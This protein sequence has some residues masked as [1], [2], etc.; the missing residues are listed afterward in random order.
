MTVT[1]DDEESDDGKIRASD[2]L[3]VETLSK[4]PSATQSKSTPYKTVA[5][6]D[7]T[8]RVTVKWTPPERTHKYKGD[9]ED[10][11]YGIISNMIPSDVGILYRWDSKD[12]VA[13]QSVSAMTASE[14]RDFISPVVAFLHAQQRI[15]FRLRIGFTTTPGQW[16]RSKAMITFFKSQQIEVSISNSTSNSGKMVTAGYV[17]LKAPNTTHFSRYTQF[18]RSVLPENENVLRRCATQ[19]DANGPTDSSSSYSVWGE[20]CHTLV[21][22]ATPG[23]NRPW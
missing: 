19:K 4:S 8:H 1:E 15:V 23:V 12:L 14:L 2:I 6:N 5:T 22:S 13:S 10:S 16:M 17:Q 20:T 7:G 18:L 3:E 9:K 21:S 11:I